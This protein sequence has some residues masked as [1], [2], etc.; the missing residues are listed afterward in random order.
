MP[1]PE[2][3]KNKIIIRK[4]SGDEA[5]IDKIEK[6]KGKNAEVAEILQLIL[7]KLERMNK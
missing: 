2:K 4:E 5:V 6:L 1:K 7:N 3:Q